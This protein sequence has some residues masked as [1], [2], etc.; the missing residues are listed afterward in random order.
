MFCAVQAIDQYLLCL[1]PYELWAVNHIRQMCMNF[2]HFAQIKAF[3]V[4]PQNW[5][6]FVKM[7]GMT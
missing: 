4:C 1:L 2:I 5:I 6:E 7:S 3:A